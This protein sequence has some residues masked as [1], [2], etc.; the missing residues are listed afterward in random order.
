MRHD[1]RITS[2]AYFLS[3]P[4]RFRVLAADR[5]GKHRLAS[6]GLGAFFRWRGNFFATKLFMNGDFAF[7]ALDCV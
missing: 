7:G 5:Q 3:M 2:G 4:D 6:A 1:P